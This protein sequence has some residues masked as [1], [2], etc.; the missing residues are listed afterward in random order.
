MVTVYWADGKVN[1]CV[2][3]TKRCGYKR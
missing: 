2:V 1:V 3:K